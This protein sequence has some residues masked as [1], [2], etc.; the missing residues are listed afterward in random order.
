[1][2]ISRA[3]HSKQTKKKK[4]TMMMM[5]MMR[6]RISWAVEEYYIS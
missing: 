2:K 5:M 6:V 1:L 3:V 4:A